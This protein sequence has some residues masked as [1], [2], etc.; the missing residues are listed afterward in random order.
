MTGRY[1]TEDRALTRAGVLMQH[2]TWPGVIRRT[3]GTF[4][5]TYDPGDAPAER[6]Q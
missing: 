2:G 4:G 1:A 3:D 6:D 5:L